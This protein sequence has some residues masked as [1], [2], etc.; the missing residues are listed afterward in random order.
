MIWFIE[1]NGVEKRE[2]I[3]REIWENAAII[4][5]FHWDHDDAF[6]K[7][8]LKKKKDPKEKFE[9]MG[10]LSWFSHH[11]TIDRHTTTHPFVFFRFVFPFFVFSKRKNHNFSRS[12]SQWVSDCCGVV[13]IC[14][15]WRH[16]RLDE[17]V[18]PE[19]RGS[20]RSEQ[21]GLISNRVER[22]EI[23][24]GDH[25][26]TY[27]A[28]FAYSHHGTSLYISLSP[29]R[30]FEIICEENDLNFAYLL[31]SVSGIPLAF[32]SWIWVFPCDW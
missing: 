22:S 7:R 5:S 4:S 9:W 15:N 18:D 17:E 30:D 8:M 16:W 27:R 20:R 1:R 11:P 2:K 26:Y 13:E 10:L 31:I 19:N 21:M 6:L 24:P 32:C 12:S 28:V 25:I 14:S 29:L 3:Y 23:K